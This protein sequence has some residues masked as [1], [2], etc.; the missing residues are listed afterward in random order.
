MV[1]GDNLYASGIVLVTPLELEVLEEAESG[2]VR[3]TV[4]D[5]RTKDLVPKV[6][7]EVIGSENA[8]FLSGETDLRG[9]FVAEGVRG[10][11]AA[12]ARQGTSRYA[13][14]RGTTRVGAPQCPGFRVLPPRTPTSRR[15]RPSPARP[16]RSTRTSRA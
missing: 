13:F 9:V 1:R 11:V 10:Q 12:V 6:Q 2:R 16:S 3:V 14:Y 8:G 4:R 5:A 15:R 7:V